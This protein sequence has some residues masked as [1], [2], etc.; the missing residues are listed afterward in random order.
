MAEAQDTALVCPAHGS[1]VKPDNDICEYAQIWGD[2]W[3]DETGIEWTK[4][5]AVAVH[6]TYQRRSE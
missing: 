1:F 2:R 6:I 4:C 3:K 5:P